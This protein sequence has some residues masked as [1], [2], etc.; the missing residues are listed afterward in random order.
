M[1]EGIAYVRMDRAFAVERFS[2]GIETFCGAEGISAGADAREIFCELYGLETQCEALEASDIPLRLQ[3]VARA[4][5]YLDFE[6]FAEGGGLLLMLTDVSETVVRE[7]ELLQVRNENAL[8]V[9]ELNAY[10]E[11]LQRSVAEAVAAVRQSDMLLVEQSRFATMGE[12][13]ANIAHQWRQP[14]NALNLVLFSLKDAF[15]HDELDEA[16]VNAFYEKCE[17][18]IAGMSQTIDDFRY[19][20]QPS[21]GR[22]RFGLRAV[23]F[24]VLQLVEE[25]AR[26]AGITIE[27]A[28]EAD[29]VIEGFRSQ[30]MQTVLNLVGNSID[31]FAAAGP[32]PSRKIVFDI[33]RRDGAVLFC[34]ADNAGGIDEGILAYVFDPYFTTKGEEGTGLGLYMTKVII[35]KN[36]DGTVSAVNADGGVRFEIALPAGGSGEIA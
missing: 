31:A 25:M 11:R 30:F 34:V 13:I 33:R 36:F 4:G 7:H 2:R 17:G 26:N 5:R 1:R 24:Q 14:L 29:A 6:L 8:L 16:F 21:T 15:E 19:F 3:T 32:R 12:M 20:F 9:A 18:L 35:E 28:S 27:W 23:V 10:N 22:E